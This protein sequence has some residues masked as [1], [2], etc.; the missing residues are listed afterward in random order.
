MRNMQI[1]DYVLWGNPV[2]DWF[3]ALG[4]SIAI[5][6]ILFLV[7]HLLVSR[8]RRL[9]GK[10]KTSVD[11]FLVDL[12]SKSGLLLLPALSLYSGSMYLKFK[13]KTEG[14]ID[15]V[16]TIVIMLQVAVWLNES[17]SFVLGKWQKRMTGVRAG[18]KTTIAI[19]SFSSRLLLWSLVLLSALNYFN[20]NVTT[21]IGALGIG[22]IAIA[23]AVQT[24]LGDVLGSLSIVMD[25]PFQ[26]GDFI[27]I[28]DYMGTIEE[29]GW[30]TTR[31]RSLSGEQIVISNSD[32]LRSRIRNYTRMAERRVVFRVG[33]EYG[34]PVRKI[35][36]IPG[37][38]K[39]IVEAQK[40]V[41]FDRAHLAEYGPYSLVFE[42]VYWV[43][44]PD[45]NF[46]M[47]IHQSVLV[48]VLR[49]FETEKIRIAFP[50]QTIYHSMPD[51]SAIVPVVNAGR[52]RR[53]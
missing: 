40:S 14:V 28:D 11:D 53:R 23:L 39:T 15:S 9:A 41:R 34:T 5:M 10:T 44:S 37:H 17:I 50:S 12:L 8:L 45:Y 21:L 20:I 30:K 7:R 46:F 24:L 2:K 42:V 19:V 25:K 38:L 47:D 33:V 27:R 1:L 32:L 4:I 48:D 13:E 43:L 31:V 6:A 51:G 18:E 52:S 29:L 22:G 36:Q 49:K 35:E 26:V 16:L 3:I